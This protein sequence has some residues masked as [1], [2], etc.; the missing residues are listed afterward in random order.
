M[1]GILGGLVGG[2]PKLT[3]V[4]DNLLHANPGAT[5]TV[6][7]RIDAGGQIYTR[8]AGGGY[9][10]QYNWIIPAANAAL[11]ECR[12]VTEGTTPDTTP[13]ASGTWVQCNVDRTWE[14]SETGA[15][16]SFSFTLQIGLLG[17][18]TALRSATIQFNALGSP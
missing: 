2:G 17:T 7:I 15:D 14:E 10:A 13:A 1:T 16:R 12:W 8:E 9:T 6:G 3:L 5:A 4:D 11:Y 18:S